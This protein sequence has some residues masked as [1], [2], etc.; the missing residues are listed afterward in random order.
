MNSPKKM[1]LVVGGAGYI[2]RHAIVELYASGYEVLVLDNFCNSNKGVFEKIIPITGR[3][4]PFIEGDVRDKSV[5]DKIFLENNIFVNAINIPDKNMAL[6]K[7][8]RTANNP[9]SKVKTIVVSQPIPFEYN[10]ISVLEKPIS[11]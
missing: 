11:L 7:P 8:I 1:I 9:P 6:T 3:E 5:L 2:G 10:A 4:V